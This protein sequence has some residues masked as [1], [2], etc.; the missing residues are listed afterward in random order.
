MFGKFFC[1]KKKLSEDEWYEQKSGL[2]ETILGKE[3]NMVMHAFIAYAVGGALDIFF[4]PNGIPGTALATKELSNA[5][6]DS[7]TNDK[8]EKYELVMFT[9]AAL[10]LE[11]A[12]NPET[13]FGKAHDNIS[14]ILNPIA[15]YSEEAKLNPNE[16]CEFPA[17]M[18]DIGG[19]C[20]I[21]ADYVAKTDK[22]E[23]FGLLAVI[24]IHRS[25]MQFAMENSGAALLNMLKE[26][27]HYPYSDLDREPVV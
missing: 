6:Q 11:A 4:Y 19:K 20:L 14:R 26:H 27:G 8:F 17:D 18:E 7:S 1:K 5:C 24:E 9:R 22:K 23:D 21:F 2:M 13:P 16:T 25:E 10:D 3:H 12:K 15:H